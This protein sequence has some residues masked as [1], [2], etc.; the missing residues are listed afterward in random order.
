MFKHAV[1]EC[2]HCHKLGQSDDC[3]SL[4]DGWD[5]VPNGETND[6]TQEWTFCAD[7]D[8]KVVGF[9]DHGKAVWFKD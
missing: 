3:E 4:P 8:S 2:D 6:V 1:Y 7:C 9:D 5:W